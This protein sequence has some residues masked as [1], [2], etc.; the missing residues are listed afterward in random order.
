MNSNQ[1]TKC[2]SILIEYAVKNATVSDSI[3]DFMAASH[4]HIDGCLRRQFSIGQTEGMLL[5]LMKASGVVRPEDCQSKY[6]MPPTCQELVLSVLFSEGVLLSASRTNHSSNYRNAGSYIYW[7]VVINVPKAEQVFAKSIW[8]RAD[9]DGAYYDEPMSI[10]RSCWPSKC[11]ARTTMHFLR[12]PSAFTAKLMPH[13]AVVISPADLSLNPK[14]ELQD[15][16]LLRNTLKR[17]VSN[18]FAACM[19]LVTGQDMGHCL[20]IDFQ[21]ESMAWTPTVE[22]STV[23]RMVKHIATMERVHKVSGETLHQVSLL[24]ELYIKHGQGRAFTNWVATELE[25]VLFND[26]GK[27]IHDD[28]FGQTAKDM[29]KYMS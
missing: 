14:R 1:I 5:S 11:S 25:A 15:R 28:V 13:G 23:E 10:E 12:D 4:K 2:M 20:G 17:A 26:P 24:K 21:T 6:D 19:T 7:D 16:S 27:Y 18:N 8:V 3:Q 29:L 9:F 22:T